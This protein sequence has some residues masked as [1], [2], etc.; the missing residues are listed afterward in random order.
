MNIEKKQSRKNYKTGSPLTE[1]YK[2]LVPWGENIYK[3]KVN[4]EI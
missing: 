3:D 1:D 4:Y 2:D